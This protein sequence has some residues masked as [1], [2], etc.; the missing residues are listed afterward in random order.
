MLAASL[1]VV[2]GG[3]LTVM[4]RWNS[5]AFRMD[6]LPSAS[7]LIITDPM[8][9]SSPVSHTKGHK[10]QHISRQWRMEHCQRMVDTVGRGIEQKPTNVI[11]LE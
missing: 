7:V 2:S 5:S 8:D 9:L 10:G 1:P 11:L 3:A 6:L 4:R